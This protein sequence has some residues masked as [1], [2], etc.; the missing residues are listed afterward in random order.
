MQQKYIKQS[1]LCLVTQGSHCKHNYSFRPF[2]DN[3][4]PL[5]RCCIEII[6]IESLQN[7]LLKVCYV[8]ATSAG[9]PRVSF[10]SFFVAATINSTNEANKAGMYAIKQFLFLDVYDWN[11]HGPILQKLFYFVIYNC[12]KWAR[13]FVPC[14]YLQPRQMFVGNIRCLTWKVL[15]SVKYRPCPQALF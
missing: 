8:R 4:V 3:T 11:N 15:Y 14:K 6:D 7:R 2:N 1:Y 5:K 13:V 10:F 9:L 12:Y